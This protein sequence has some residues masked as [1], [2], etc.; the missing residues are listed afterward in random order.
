[1]DTEKIV[2]RTRK[3]DSGK[4][5]DGML[6]R[7]KP[8]DI[9]EF[10]YE[11]A[12]TF[13]PDIG[14]DYTYQNFQV[15]WVQSEKHIRVLAHRIKTATGGE[16][17]TPFDIADIVIETWADACWVQVYYSYYPDFAR[18]VV[19]H[20]IQ[21]QQQFSS[22]KAATTDTTPT[23]TA[24]LTDRQI[25]V[26]HLLAKGFYDKEIAAEL[27][28]S[29]H[30][31]REHRKKIAAKWKTKQTIELMQHIARLKGYGRG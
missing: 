4:I 9:F 20:L 11:L 22:S 25:E 12:Q 5:F 16:S 2:W 27:M 15:E 19:G 18:A 10:V 21:R 17:V 1:M 30:T 8:D 31:P 29:K 13:W 14:D 28:I 6:E 3:M 23:D 24:K 26:A 7:A